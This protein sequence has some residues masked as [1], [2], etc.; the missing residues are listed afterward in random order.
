M[1]DCKC[2]WEKNGPI[3]NWDHVQNSFSCGKCIGLR[4]CCYFMV[5]LCQVCAQTY[6]QIC[7]YSKF[8]I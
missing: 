8:N 2:V 7:D 3:L 1:G 5:A 4:K 6:M